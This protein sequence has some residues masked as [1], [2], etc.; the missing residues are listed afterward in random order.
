M[1]FIVLVISAIIAVLAFIGLPYVIENI[2]I[3]SLAKQK[4]LDY[5]T[6]MGNTTKKNKKKKSLI[7]SENLFNLIRI[8]DSFRNN[9]LLSGVNVRPEEFIL[10]WFLSIFTLGIITF[11]FTV[12]IISHCDFSCCIYAAY[13]YQS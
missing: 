13:V 9:I 12:D 1:N 3:T 4:R 5:I 2:F 7:N 10:I 11:T 8:S 6:G